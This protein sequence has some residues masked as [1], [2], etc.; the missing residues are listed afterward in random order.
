LNTKDLI[1]VWRDEAIKVILPP[2]LQHLKWSPD[3]Q[4]YRAWSEDRYYLKFKKPINL[5]GHKIFYALYIP[6]KW[7]NNYYCIL[8][9]KESLSYHQSNKISQKADGI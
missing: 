5:K 7:R 1:E 8:T 6:C 4:L 3:F 2:H 9:N